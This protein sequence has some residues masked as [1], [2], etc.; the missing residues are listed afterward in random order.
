MSR[1]VEV[2][3]HLRGGA[4]YALVFLLPALES[5]SFIGFRFPGELAVLLGGVL[6]Y[7]GRVSLPWVAAAAIAGAIVGDS[8]GYAVGA[9]WG[10][11]LFRT[12]IV[13]RLVSPERRR[14]AEEL[15]RRRGAAAVVIGR[16]TAVARVLARFRRRTPPRSASCTGGSTPPGPPPLP[17]HGAG[18]QR[19]GR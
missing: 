19:P 1:V 17:D 8:V 13:H 14:R 12:S 2:I 6:A 15:L 5:S 7:Q 11:V 18:A 16:F 4:A 3:L 10:E 9:R